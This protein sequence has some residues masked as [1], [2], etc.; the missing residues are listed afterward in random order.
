MRKLYIVLIPLLLAGCWDEQNYNTTIHVPMAGISGELGEVKVS[1]ALPA[2]ERKTEE[3]RFIT[4]DGLSF[5]DAKT[6]ADA[7]THNQL[8]TTM[9]TALLIDE[10]AAKTN[11]YGYLDSFYRDVKNRLGM[12]LIITK[13]PAQ[14]YIEKGSEFGDN[15]NTFYSEM[16]HHLVEISQLPLMDLQHACTYLF[17]NGIDLQLPYMENREEDDFPFI[18]GVA[19]FDDRKFTGEV[20]PIKE[21]VIMQLL[22]EDLGKK[23]IETFLFK[24]AAMSYEIDKQKRKVELHDNAVNLEYKLDVSILDFYP[25]RIIKATNR[26]E[27][28]QAIEKDLESR[29]QEIIQI[30]QQ[31]NHDGLGLGRYYRAFRPE[32]FTNNNWKDVYRGLEIRTSF[33]VKIG[34]SGIMD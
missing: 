4:V 27:M 21:M 2:I 11:I 9:L 28:E 31:A 26:Y 34:D 33:E 6:I 23:A 29:A 19:L 18:S 12:S 13:G 20:I 8:D 10:R 16:T 24:D 14:P 25:D 17:D 15:I 32:Q 5:H 7:T 30:M 1:F 22:K 3:A